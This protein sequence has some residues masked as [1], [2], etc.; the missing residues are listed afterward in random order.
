MR[1]NLCAILALVMLFTLLP[2]GALAAKSDISGEYGDGLRWEL[3]GDGTLTITGR[4]ARPDYTQDSLVMDENIDEQS[5]APWLQY[6]SALRAIVIGEGVTRVGDYTF[7]N[8]RKV[9][10]IRLPSTLRSI[11]KYAFSMNTAESLTLPE[12][13]QEI[14]PRAF[15]GGK[16]TEI[17]VPASVKKL[18]E[19]A[20]EGCESAKVIKVLGPV[21]KLESHTF[22][23]CRPA[24]LFLS[25]DIRSM[26]RDVFQIDTHVWHVYCDGTKA[27][28][29]ENTK[30]LDAFYYAYLHTNT[31]LDLHP[32]FTDVPVGTWYT[33]SVQW[34][35]ERSF[36]SGTT[37]TTF[38]PDAACT[39]AQIV[40]F[41]WRFCGSP[42]MTNAVNP[43]RDV[44]ESDYFY[45]AVIW[46]VENGITNG[47]SGH[48]FSP[49]KIVTR[50]ETVTFFWRKHAQT[51][52]NDPVKKFSDVPKD[53]YYAL[54]VD[55]AVDTGLTN[56]VSEDL[57][58]PDQSCSRAQIV[59]FLHRYT[60][61]WWG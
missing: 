56:G 52:P 15:A 37:A 48:T 30:N 59:T 23:R 14:G 54:A 51:V 26:A 5:P 10:S 8:D 46:A 4:G 58:G 27:R 6:D 45:Q 25:K 38:S 40:T 50:A 29:L 53:A 34:A 47:T 42:E 44:H 31:P 43:F 28:F 57:F 7:M 1:N 35:A 21:E 19:G 20:F 11:G 3:S 22:Y 2:F 33:D 17:V 39:R 41:L 60:P 13:L 32:H 36:T 9:T 12:G 16:M 61:R 18:G 24:D 49:D 55:W